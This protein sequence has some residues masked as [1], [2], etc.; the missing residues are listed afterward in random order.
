M[1][2]PPLPTVMRAHHDE[3]A[4]SAQQGG[5]WKARTDQAA[6][7]GGHNDGRGHE[8]KLEE[9]RPPLPAEGARADGHISAG[10]GHAEQDGGASSSSR[11]G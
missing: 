8:G 10:R 1:L 11:L 5:Q 9:Q 4:G 3:H 7:D 2:P 6:A